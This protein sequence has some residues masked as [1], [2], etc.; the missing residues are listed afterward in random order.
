MDLIELI[1]LR[2][3]SGRGN[4]R[5]QRQENSRRDNRG[6]RITYPPGTEM[7]L[8]ANQFQVAAPFWRDPR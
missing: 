5:D 1:V 2:M 7:W 4:E 8:P 6:Y 3:G